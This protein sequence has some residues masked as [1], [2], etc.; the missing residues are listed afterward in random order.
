MFS[1]FRWRP[2]F[3]L[4]TSCVSRSTRFTVQTCFSELYL[5]EMRFRGGK[6]EAGLLDDSQLELI[7]HCTALEYQCSLLL[8]FFNCLFCRLFPRCCE[9][10]TGC[11]AGAWPRVATASPAAGTSAVQSGCFFFFFCRRNG[12]ALAVWRLI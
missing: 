3:N 9:D 8:F 12:T 5:D 10:A 2:T 1:L 7:R 11:G 6:M 4:P